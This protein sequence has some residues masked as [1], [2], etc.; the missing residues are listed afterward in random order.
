MVE[1]GDVLERIEHMAF[2]N[3]NSLI[4]IAMPL[5]CTIDVNAF[6][7][8]PMLIAIDV[9][10]VIRKSISSLHMECWR[11]EMNLAINWIN[12]ELT[13][14][15]ASTEEKPQVIEQWIQTVLRRMEDYRTRHYIVVKEAMTLLEL[16]LWKAKLDGS[17]KDDS[18]KEPKTKRAKIDSSRKER[19]VTCGANII[20]KNV[21]PFVQ[22]EE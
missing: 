1:F 3:C 21:L 15:S 12:K 6:Y 9:V 7:E 19:R 17:R 18:L 5:D 13:L 22:F 2:D 10:G 11:H 8:C 4:R 20:I 14:S 16:A